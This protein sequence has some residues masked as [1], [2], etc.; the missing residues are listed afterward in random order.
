M[1]MQTC[2]IIGIAKGL[3]DNAQYLTQDMWNRMC[4]TAEK[5]IIENISSD[6]SEIH[7]VS[8]GAAWGDH[9]AVHLHLQHPESLLTLHLPCQWDHIKHQHYDNGQ[10]DWKTNAGKLA[11]EYHRKFQKVVGFDSLLQ[12]QS[13]IDSKMAKINIYKGFHT[14]NLAVGKSQHLLA[15]SFSLTDEPTDGGT[16]YTWRLSTSQYKTHYSVLKLIT[17]NKN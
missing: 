11:N 4:Q 16:A 2:S 5:H 15:F 7:L 17:D 8:G 6:W 3:G 13:L 14:R 12:I 9:I 10:Y 1:L